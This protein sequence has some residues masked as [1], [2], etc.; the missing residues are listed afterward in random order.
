MNACRNFSK[1]HPIMLATFT[2][3]FMLGLLK[4]MG[5]VPEGPLSFGIRESIMAVLVFLVTFLFMGK[6]K[7]NFSTKGFGYGF[8]LLRGYYIFLTIFAVISA[9]GIVVDSMSKNEAISYSLITFVNI[10][11]VGLFVG[12]V[13]EFTFRGLIF[14]GILQKLGN[15]KKSVILAAVISGLLFGV[16][17]VLGSILAGEITTIQAVITATLKTLQCAIF[18][19]VLAFIYFKTRNLFVVAALHSLDDFILFVVGSLE[20]QEAGNY[21]ATDGNITGYVI[22][23]GLFTVILIPNLVRCIKDF[24]AEEAIPFDDDFEARKV[25]FEKK[26]KKK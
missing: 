23:Y 18:G 1:Q 25:V 26:T 5:F 11:I 17:H 22:A 6:E 21:V 13:E 8:R 19:V 3:I 12:I 24:K 14:G 20:K 15:S 2:F 16:L 10:S 7:V 9:I 4:L